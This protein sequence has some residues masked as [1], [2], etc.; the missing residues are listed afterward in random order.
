M[1]HQ[2]RIPKVP[3]IDF[4]QT[5]F[6]SLGNYLPL[7]SASSCRKLAICSTGKAQNR[8]NTASPFK[9]LHPAT[10]QSFFLRMLPS[11]DAKKKVRRWRCEAATGCR[12]KCWLNFASNYIILYSISI[13]KLKRSSFT[14]NVLCCKTQLF[15]SQ[16]DPQLRSSNFKKIWELRFHFV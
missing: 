2:L 9:T 6:L 1:S 16:R 7:F 12:V 5:I 13:F 3:E 4:P 15:F 14:V 10:F 11:F 8:G